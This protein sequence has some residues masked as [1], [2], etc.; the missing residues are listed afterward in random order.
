[1]FPVAA[2]MSWVSHADSSGAGTGLSSATGVAGSTATGPSGAGDNRSALNTHGGRGLRG[3]ACEECARE[4]GRLVQA[5]RMGRAIR[6][7]DGRQS[8]TLVPW[9]AT[10]PP[11]SGKPSNG[12]AAVR[13]EAG[14]QLFLHDTAATAEKHRG[15]TTTTTTKHLTA[16]DVEERR[17]ETATTN[18]NGSCRSRFAIRSNSAASTR[19]RALE[20][21]ASHGTVIR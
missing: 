10:E 1:M 15:K 14:F 11:A 5:V 8:E 17:G 3:C 6:R 16:E 2:I 21:R 9:V 20:V 18:G 12:A 19:G 13:S 7:S 4:T